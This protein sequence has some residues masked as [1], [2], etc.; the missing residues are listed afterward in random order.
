MRNDGKTVSQL[1][2]EKDAQICAEL[3]A[4]VLRQVEEV[5]FFQFFNKQDLHV[6][7]NEAAL[8]HD[9]CQKPL[10]SLLGCHAGDLVVRLL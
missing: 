3:L 4:V 6:V 2:L 8:C 5:T 7:I 9:R 10:R 1:C